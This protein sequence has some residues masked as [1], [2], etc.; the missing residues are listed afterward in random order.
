LIVRFSAVS[1][2]AL[3]S[4]D[5]TA[6]QFRW[7]PLRSS[8]RFRPDVGRRRRSDRKW[9][10]HD[11]RSV[12][13]RV[14]DGAARQS[15]LQMKRA[16]TDALLSRTRRSRAPPLRQ[17]NAQLT[18]VLAFVSAAKA[19]AIVTEET[20]HAKTGVAAS[21]W[22]SPLSELHPAAD[23]ATLAAP[24]GRETRVPGSCFL[25]GLEVWAVTR[26][27]SAAALRS[28][29]HSVIRRHTQPARRRSRAVAG[30]ACSAGFLPLT[31]R[32]EPS[33]EHRTW[34]LRSYHPPATAAR[35]AR[36]K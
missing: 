18:P 33:G 16:G 8:S 28:M 26:A 22:L 5:P 1:S 6:Q 34:R 14:P 19:V 20:V 12:A 10:P 11:G 3:A 25:F 23:K 27:A 35:G 4:S 21:A 36:L 32:L 31:I 17:T 15:P 9:F 29:L 13:G 2:D 30:K 7:Q 24:S